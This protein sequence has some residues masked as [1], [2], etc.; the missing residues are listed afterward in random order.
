V[1]SSD[2]KSTFEWVTDDGESIVHMK[3]RGFLKYCVDITM[4]R[5]ALKWPELPW[6]IALLFYQMIMAR[7]ESASHAAAH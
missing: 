5:S 3:G 2:L 6:L 1:C 4:N 7:R